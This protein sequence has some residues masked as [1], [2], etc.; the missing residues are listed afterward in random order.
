MFHIITIISHYFL[1]TV[2][3]FIFLVNG[4]FV[5][6][7]YSKMSLFKAFVQLVS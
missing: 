2:L 7:I 3:L 1:A 5:H 6:I 4:G